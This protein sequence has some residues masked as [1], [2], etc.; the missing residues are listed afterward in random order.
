MI[1]EELT[2]REL[3]FPHTQDKRT[4]ML[5]DILDNVIGTKAYQ[6]HDVICEFR[7]N[8]PRHDYYFFVK[9]PRPYTNPE[10]LCESVYH[11]IESVL[12]WYDLSDIVN[13]DIKFEDGNVRNKC[14]YY[15]LAW[16]GYS[17]P[18]P[19]GEKP[20]YSNEKLDRIHKW[21]QRKMY[22]ERKEYQEKMTR[23]LGGGRM[24][25]ENTEPIDQKVIHK[26]KGFIMKVKEI[27]VN[28]SY[29]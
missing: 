17:R 2:I 23:A 21:M 16:W 4:L 20:S 22:D 6:K 10:I 13:F 26:P 5:N 3:S 27:F 29:V 8:Y 14:T 1:R 12:V 11:L 18:S 15:D 25:Y 19:F 28:L 24:F 9:T 7:C